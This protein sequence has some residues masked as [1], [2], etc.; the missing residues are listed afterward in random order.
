MGRLDSFG[1]SL[2]RLGVKLQ[3]S[4]ATGTTLFLRLR[5]DAFTLEK[6]LGRNSTDWAKQ[7]QQ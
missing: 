6:D 7:N 5:S 3:A 2:Q 4:K 1:A